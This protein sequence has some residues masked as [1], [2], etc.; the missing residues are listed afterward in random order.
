MPKTD[1]LTLGGYVAPKGPK[2]A[3]KKPAAKKKTPAKK[4]AVKKAPG[5]PPSPDAF[6]KNLRAYIARAS[7]STIVKIGA[8]EAIKVELL[9]EWD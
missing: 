2:L 8:L 6:H 9:D 5:K 4:P 1:E 3:K 7:V